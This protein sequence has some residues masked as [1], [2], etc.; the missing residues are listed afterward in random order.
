[1]AAPKSGGSATSIRDGD[2]FWK[3][4]LNDLKLVGNSKPSLVDNG[5]LPVASTPGATADL[6]PHGVLV[7]PRRFSPS[8]GIGANGRPPPVR[9]DS[10]L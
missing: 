6:A 3:D 8:T 2:T 9:S 5:K 4:L 1:M 7:H 10:G